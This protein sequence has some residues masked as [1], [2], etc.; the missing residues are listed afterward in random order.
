MEYYY[1]DQSYNMDPLVLQNTIRD[2]KIALKY[3]KALLQEKRS[4]KGAWKTELDLLELTIK[5]RE[6]MI[7][8]LERQL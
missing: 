8:N 6:K 4:R 3:E 2:L 1:L 5:A 7:S